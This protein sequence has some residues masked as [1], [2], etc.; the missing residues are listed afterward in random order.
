MLLLVEVWRFSPLEGAVV[1]SALPVATLAMLPLGPRLS[2]VVPAVGGVVLLA[3]GLVGLAWLPDTSTGY[4]VAALAACGA[5]LGLLTDLLGPVALDT[6]TG[7][8]RAGTVNNA[9]RHAGLVLGLALIAPVLA[10]GL[11]DG[12]RDAAYAGTAALLDA[13]LVVSEKVPLAWEL[14][15]TIDATPKGEVPDLE[16]VFEARGSAEDEALRVA[17]DDLVGA[18]E[19]VLTRAFRP[20]FLLAATFG[21]LAVIPALVVAR[22]IRRP[23]D[24]AAAVTVAVLGAATLVLLSVEWRA[25]AADFGV[26]EAEDACSADSDPFPGDGLDATFQRIALGAINGAACESGTTR[27][28]L[29]LSLDPDSELGDVTFDQETAERGAALPAPSGPS[30]TPT[31]ATHCQGWS[32]LRW[33]SS[34]S[35]HRS[36]G[37]STGF[38]SLD[39]KVGSWPPSR[40][41]ATACASGLRSWGAAAPG[42]A[43]R[44]RRP[45]TATP[46][47]STRTATCRSGSSASTPLSRACPCLTIPIGSSR[48]ATRPGATTCS[49]RRARSSLRSASRCVS[50]SRG[51]SS[52]ATPRPTRPVTRP[53]HGKR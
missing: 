7:L 30:R 47:R 18:I 27:E 42:T 39:R 38:H 12:A 22:R 14:R 10:A 1:V 6:E 49:R 24:S 48:S 41:R 34:S 9:A 17:Q 8:L 43:A 2:G 16:P 37:C 51:A 33:S 31:S 5:G 29:V 15:E 25:G 35:E 53:Q 46:C 26:H 45:S 52:P 3:G 44:P 21:A 23:S 50:T 28:K 19:A 20:S 36:T 4:V 13:Q 11:E 32:R 40:R